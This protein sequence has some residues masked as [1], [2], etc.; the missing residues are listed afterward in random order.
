MGRPEIDILGAAGTVT[1]SCYLLSCGDE[2]ILVDCGLFQG[3]R[4]LEELNRER[5][6]FNPAKLAA[7]LLTHAHLDHSGLLPRLYAEGFRGPIW[8]TGST[9][10][11]LA[12]MLPDAA[13]IHEMDTERRNQ[14]WD[15]ADEP[16]LKPLYTLD[17]AL[18]A[19]ELRRVVEPDLTERVS[20]HFE[21]RFW[22]AGHI[23]GSAS[24]EV[25][26]E[27][28]RL[29]FSGDIGPSNKSFHSEP[30][31]PSGV[32]HL[33]CES[34][35]GDR[36]RDPVTIEQRRDLLEQEVH[37]ALG[38]GGNLLIPVFALERTQELLLD[39]AYLLNSGRLKS[40]NVF[41]D[42]P[43]ASKATDVFRRHRHQLEDL[44][45][46]EVFNH[47][48]FHFVE[49]VE[50]SMRLDAVSGAIILAASGMCEGGRVRHHLRNNLPRSDS[51]VLFVGYQAKGT[52]GRTLADGAGRVRISGHDVAV[53]AH[54]RRLESYS[55]HADQGELVDWVKARQPINGSLF[56]TH[57]EEN[58][59][60]V[61]RDKIGEREFPI[62]IPEI[63]ERYQLAAGQP[64]KRL[65]TGRSDLRA[66]VGGDWQNRYADLAVNLKRDLQRIE[67][68]ERR[69]EA[70]GQMREILDRFATPAKKGEKR[71][72]K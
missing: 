11:L 64:A 59:T 51:T 68:N 44:E 14:R 32:D 62:I 1:G 46:G 57:G 19:L 45:H 9:G 61:L 71:K 10:D 69:L 5:F 66:V 21:A 18:G 26:A 70:L 40:T 35:Y 60:K 39:L 56:L 48:K 20:S 6:S 7:V 49:S 3:S 24:I 47:P 34:T 42:S 67:S 16:P 37:R 29:V 17:D 25:M 31:G 50:V 65:K 55:A 12:V 28:V 53:R 41:I 27:G 38:L 13:K 8:C 30:E 52:L 4:T 2:K 33:F 58:A 23:L 63:G 15:R 54:V 43:L 22:N 36:P 72:A